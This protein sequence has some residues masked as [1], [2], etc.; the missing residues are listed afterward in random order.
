MFSQAGHSQIWAK[1]LDY[2]FVDFP[3]HLLLVTVFLET[4]HRNMH[5]SAIAIFHMLPKFD[6]ACFAH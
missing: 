4:L 5:E 1:L 6:I 2:V 3:E